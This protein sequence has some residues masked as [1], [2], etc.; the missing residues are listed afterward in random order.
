MAEAEVRLA[1]VMNGGVSLAVWIAGVTHEIDL[2]R[3]A[4]TDDTPDSQAYDAPVVRRWRELLRPDGGGERRHLVVDV[5]A[6]TSAGGLNGA[7]LANVIAHNGTIDPAPDTGGKS[8][9]AQPDGPWLREVWCTLGAL[10]TGKLLPPG[11]QQNTGS[12]LDGQFFLDQAEDIMATLSGTG[13]ATRSAHPVTLFTTASGLGRQSF[14]A[15]DAA[16]QKFDVSDHRFLYRFSTDVSWDYHPAT[17]T[18]TPPEDQQADFRDPKRL[19]LAARASASFPVAFEPVNEGHLLNQ[20]RP[21]RERPRR[22]GTDPSWLMD[23]GVL[24]NAPFGPVLD[25][26]AKGAISGKVDRYVVYVVPSSGVGK[27]ATRIEPDDP[28]PSWST[29][30]GSAVQF[31]R[32]VDFRSDVEELERLRLEADTAWS[33]SQHLYEQAISNPVEHR[34][35]MSAGASLQPTY[36]RGRAAGAVWEAVTLGESGRVTLLDKAAA[37]PMEMADQIL[38]ISPRFTPQVGHPM[39][40]LT[41]GSPTNVPRWPWG[42]GPAERVLRTVLR[43]T[44]TQLET[45]PRSTD[46]AV[47]TREASHLMSQ[48]ATLSRS[49]QHVF[50]LR[51]AVERGIQQRYSELVEAHLGAGEPPSPSVLEVAGAINTVFDDL[52]VQEALGREFADLQDAIPDGR[53]QLATALAVEVVSR[54]TSSRTP[55]Q[56]SVPFSFVRLGPD[57][58]LPVLDADGQALADRLGDRVLYGTQV[59]HF[60]AFGADKWRRWD[61]LMGR[62]HAVSHLGTLLHDTSTRAKRED[63]TTWIQE[64]QLAVLEAE[65]S[66]P[67]Q[68]L[69]GLRTLERDYPVDSTRYGAARMLDAMNDADMELPEMQASTRQIGERLVEVSPGLGRTPGRWIT[70]VTSLHQPDSITTPERLARWFATPIREALW[71]KL[72]AGRT[73]PDEPESLSALKTWPWALTLLAGVALVVLAALVVDGSAVGGLILACCGGAVVLGG[74]VGLVAVNRLSKMREL[75]GTKFRWQ[76]GT[77][78]PDRGSQRPESL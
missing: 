36:T 75:L 67:E 49:R 18:F 15:T 20:L 22:T 7:M 3:R 46:A 39:Q 62:L 68:L 4:C 14:S 54:C 30:L 9:T 35:V 58:K 19:A 33:D 37:A 74:A 55:D 76:L 28:A 24:D 71:R 8:V 40:A 17:L 32:E 43:S 42:I 44:R 72:T 31:P 38:G 56:R 10:R 41:A 6:G 25:T 2:I 78:L 34:D 73:T 51:A 26:I 69:D 65:Q 59:A 16:D 52:R 45:N 21:P 13:S 23:G 57:I 53:K 27:A 48:L 1:L 66:S 77:W 60:G 5:I 64:T 29:A 70:A 50:A 47:G 63:A 61:W 11:T 12:I